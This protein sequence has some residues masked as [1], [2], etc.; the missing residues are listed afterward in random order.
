MEE[1]KSES[2]VR[3]RIN[4]GTSVKGVKTYDATIELVDEFVNQEDVKRL[5]GICLQEKDSLIAELDKRYP[6]GGDLNG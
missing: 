5:K 1:I 6:A 4:V 2:R 3:V